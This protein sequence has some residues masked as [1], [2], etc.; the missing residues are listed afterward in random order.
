MV[1]VTDPCTDR[2]I[3]HNI[4]WRLR[5][6][7]ETEGPISSVDVEVVFVFVVGVHRVAVV[8]TTRHCC[9]PCVFVSGDGGVVAVFAKRTVSAHSDR[10]RRR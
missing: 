7:H 3:K 8:V 1:V 6:Q 2:E 10:R 9:D 4:R 5:A